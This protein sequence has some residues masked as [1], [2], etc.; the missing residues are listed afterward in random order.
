MRFCLFKMSKHNEILY[1]QIYFNSAEVLRVRH[2]CERGC[3]RTCI[4][5][6]GRSAQALSHTPAPSRDAAVNKIA[7][8]PR[9]SLLIKYALSGAR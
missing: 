6:R 1:Y 7:R 3:E 2:P 4:S 5:S 9:A 8:N